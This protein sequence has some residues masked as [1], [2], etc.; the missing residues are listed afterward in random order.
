MAISDY[1]SKVIEIPLTKG[2]VAIVDELDADLLEFKWHVAI[3]RKIAYAARNTYIDR[4]RGRVY[5]H[6]I[7]LERI[8]GRQLEQ[9]ELVDH[10]NHIGTDNR[11]SNVRLASYSNNM[12]NTVLRSDNTTGYKGISPAR[13]GYLVR[14]KVNG[15]QIQLGRYETDLEAACVY[16]NAALK[17][18]GEFALLNEIPNW[19]DIFKR[20]IPMTGNYRNTSGYRGVYKKRNKWRA[21]IYSDGKAHALGS[22]DTPEEANEAVQAFLKGLISE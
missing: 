7:I 3:P 4:I 13:H 10:E 18:Y 16:N 9:G 15:K 2:Y 11:R 17:Y 6:Q 12:Q 5:M 20:A 1:T 21:S 19:Q 14:I 22:Y 8:L